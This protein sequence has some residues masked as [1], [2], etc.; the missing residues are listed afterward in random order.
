MGWCRITGL[1]VVFALAATLA[2]GGPALRPQ[3]PDAPGSTLIQL[4]A[5]RSEAEAAAS[6]VRIAHA[7]NGLL[8]GLT[9]NITP[10]KVSHKGRLYR[11]RAGPLDASNAASVC[12]AL[13]ARGI[14]CIVVR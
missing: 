6:W 14:D 9:P 5:E 11:L 13:K 3:M 4:G 12:A 1:G 2:R 8:D 10:V 7:T